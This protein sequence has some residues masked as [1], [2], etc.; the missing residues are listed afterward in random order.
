MIKIIKYLK[1]QINTKLVLGEV[2]K[3]DMRKMGISEEDA[4]NRIK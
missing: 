2:I 3:F 1:Y 4:G